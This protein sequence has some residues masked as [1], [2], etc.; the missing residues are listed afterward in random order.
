MQPAMNHSF[1]ITL[2]F[3]LGL[4]F[5]CTRC[6]LH[7]ERPLDELESFI[8]ETIISVSK[9]SEYD[10]IGIT[11]RLHYGRTNGKHRLPFR[12]VQRQDGEESLQEWCV[13]QSKV[14][15]H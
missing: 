3:L 2:L 8:D 10:R 9:M 11:R 12:P 13:E 4:E 14:Q 5:G 1:P 15:R 6:L 7:E